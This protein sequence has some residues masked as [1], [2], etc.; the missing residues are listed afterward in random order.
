VVSEK[1]AATL[2]ACWNLGENLELSPLWLRRLVHRALLEL[3]SLDE[4]EGIV[5][6]VGSEAFSEAAAPLTQ[7]GR[8]AWV[9]GS[10]EDRRFLPGA[11]HHLA[12]RVVCVHDRERTGGAGLDASTCGV[13]L[14]ATPQLLG[15]MGCK[16]VVPV[17]P[18]DVA[19]SA[20]ATQLDPR[21]DSPYSATRD[22]GSAVVSLQTSQFVVALLP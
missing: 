1:R 2:A 7:V 15:P 6:R 10:T 14:G 16:E 9:D 17:A 19:L 11:L 4:L 8:L 3:K 13:F 5:A 22:D 20:A 21:F 18:L 12:P